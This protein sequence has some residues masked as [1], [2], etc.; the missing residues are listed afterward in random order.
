M[1][2]SIAPSRRDAVE[3]VKADRVTYNGVLYS[4][5]FDPYSEEPHPH[6]SEVW[7]MT[8]L[9]RLLLSEYPP[10]PPTEKMKWV[11]LLPETVSVDVM[12]EAYNN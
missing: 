3:P 12:N 7:A 11:L 9:Q 1:P 10:M 5:P 2:P 6:E 4:R 8:L